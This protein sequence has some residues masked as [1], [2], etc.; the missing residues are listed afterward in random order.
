MSKHTPVLLNESVEALNVTKDKLYV[1]CNLGGGGHSL[2]ILQKGGIV[3]GIDLDEKAIEIAK[4]KLKDFKGRIYIKKGNFVNINDFVKDL[5]WSFVSGILYDLGLSTF[6]LKD[7]NKGFSFNDEVLMDMRMD[8]GLSVTANDLLRV[9]TVNELEKMFKLYGEEPQARVFAKSL[10]DA[11][12]KK[13]GGLT[14]KE[15]GEIIK[16][17]SKYSHSRIHPATRVFQAFRIT[18]NSELE[19]FES[20]TRAAIP[21][22]DPKGRLVTI[23]FH[24]LEDKIAKNLEGSPHLKLLNK[25]PIIPSQT[26]IYENPSSRSAKMRIYEKIN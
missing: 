19:N 13:P 3:L 2:R 17:S 8:E 25:D 5:G 9:L 10:K 24:S 20:S 12:S 1:D 14:A 6:Q 18:V 4:E 21:L 23:T 11:I 16:A 15:V 22:L 7:Q 26:E